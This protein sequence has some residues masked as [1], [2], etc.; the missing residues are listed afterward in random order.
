M[1]V[2]LILPV[3]SS[4]SG[5]SFIF[6]LILFLLLRLLILHVFPPNL[7]PNHL[8]LLHGSSAPARLLVLRL[9][10]VGGAAAGLLLMRRMWGR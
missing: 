2:L 7:F 3:F 6:R 8:R 10:D 1:S 9:G 5:S 4:S